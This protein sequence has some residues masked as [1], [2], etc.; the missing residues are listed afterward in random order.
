MR[1]SELV[2]RPMR[3]LGRLHTGREDVTRRVGI[4]RYSFRL[5][6][7]ARNTFSVRVKGGSNGYLVLD[8]SKRRCYLSEDN[9]A[10]ICTRGF[11]AVHCT[12]RLRGG[13]AIQIVMSRSDVRV[14]YSRKGAMFA[15]EVFVSRISCMGIGGLDKGFCSLGGWSYISPFEVTYDS[16]T[17]YVLGLGSRGDTYVCVELVVLLLLQIFGNI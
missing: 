10:R 5:R 15:S 7:G 12:G 11:K 16:A 13:R 17:E 3:R 14:F 9:V 6:K 4:R 8:T 2:R 1:G